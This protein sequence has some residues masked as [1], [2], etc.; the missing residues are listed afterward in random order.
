M[1]SEPFNS[2]SSS[3]FHDYIILKFSDIINIEACA[4]INNCV[5][6]L[7]QYLQEVLHLY[8]NL[9]LTTLNNPVK[10]YLLF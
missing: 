2:H 4:F 7:F 6:I 8:Q 10:A 3:Y 9:M 5:I 1:S